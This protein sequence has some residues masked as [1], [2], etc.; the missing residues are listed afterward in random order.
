MVQPF[1]FNTNDFIQ[2]VYISPMEVRQE[3]ARL[4]EEEEKEE[5]EEEE[6]EGAGKSV[7]W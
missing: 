3:E 5:E 7:W 1:P 4:E 6:E 2:R